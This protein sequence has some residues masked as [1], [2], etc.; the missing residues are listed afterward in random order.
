MRAFLILT[1]SVLAVIAAGVGISAA[2]QPPAKYVICPSVRACIQDARAS[3]ISS[4][5]FTP[6]EA[7]LRFTY[8]WVTFPQAL[9]WT[10]Y[11]QFYDAPRKQPLEWIVTSWPLP[12]P[13][14]CRVDRYW[15]S[16]V[17]A[18]GLRLCYSQFFRTLEFEHDHVLYTADGR[19]P[20]LSM[21]VALVGGRRLS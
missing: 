21:L 10:V 5:I 11:L 1:A 9:D 19:S 7:D 20:N 8:G 6:G 12:E 4:P 16:M 13:F 17:V 3:G 15:R 14:S 2:T 18:S